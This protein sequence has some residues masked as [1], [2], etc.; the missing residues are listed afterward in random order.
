MH[1]AM[2]KIIKLFLIY[3]H[4]IHCVRGLYNALIK[5]IRQ[6][7]SRQSPYLSRLI[8]SLE[9]AV[10]TISE[11]LYAVFLVTKP[12]HSSTKFW[13]DNAGILSRL[14]S[15]TFRI[16]KHEFKVYIIQKSNAPIV[17]SEDL[18]PPYHTFL[19]KRLTYNYY[20]I[21]R[22]FCL[23]QNADFYIEFSL[24]FLVVF[25]QTFNE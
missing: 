22:R 5:A 10:I 4:L 3:R 19:L 8:Y 13:C 6:E 18:L 1:P 16:F 20:N 15:D 17:Q 25:Y 14:H 11:H 23:V 9:S 12:Q 7:K 24:C 2:D 21:A